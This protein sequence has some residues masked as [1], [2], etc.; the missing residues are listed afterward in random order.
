ML[1]Y[2]LAEM[3]SFLKLG[4]INLLVLI[5]FLNLNI[6]LT[7]HYYKSNPLCRQTSLLQY[8]YNNA[9]NNKALNPTAQH[10]FST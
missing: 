9:L 4:I 6:L 7:I 1:V 3:H 10:T 2:I 8:E 5:E